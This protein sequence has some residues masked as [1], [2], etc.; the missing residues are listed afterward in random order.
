MTIKRN[1]M[2]RSKDVRHGK[3]YNRTTKI[4][5]SFPPANQAL[6]DEIPK[7]NSYPTLNFTK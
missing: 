4:S 5:T 2:S 3:E 1:N 7:R 6:A